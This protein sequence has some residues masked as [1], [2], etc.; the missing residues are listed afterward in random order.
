MAKMTTA[1]LQAAMKTYVDSAKQAGAWSNSNNNLIGLIDKVGKTMRIDGLYNDHLPELD[2]ENLPLGKTIE[3]Y[4][5]DLTLPTAFTDCATDGANDLAPALP[6]VEDVCYS[7]TLGRQYIKTTVPFDNIE[8]AFNSS[9]GAASAITDISTKLQNSYDQTMYAIKKQLLGNAISKCLAAKATNTDVYKSIAMPTDTASGEAFITEVKKDVE[10][11]SF[12]HEGGLNKALIG[13]SPELVLYVL[14]GVMPSVEVNT[15]AGAFNK[16]DLTIPAR[17][18]VVDDF[19]TITGGT[20]GKKVFA[21]L[22]DP[23]AIKTHLGYNA[24]R[25]KENGQG[26]FVNYYRHFEVTGFI[27]KYAYMKVFE[28]A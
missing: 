16:D 2:G 14:K 18:K 15:L 6:S 25:Y 27:S 1:A 17:V 12:A 26:D 20:A 23:R 4:F 9:E 19:G 28:E 7:Y 22:C 3:E 5:I 10:D 8:R 21:I 24:A 11:A 13:A